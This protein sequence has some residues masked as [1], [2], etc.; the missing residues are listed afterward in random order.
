M[1]IYRLEA[2]IVRAR[3]HVYFR[4]HRKD[5]PQK[6]KI[7]VVGHPRSGTKSLHKLFTENGLRSLHF[8]GNWNTRKYDCFSDR[9][10]YQPLGLMRAYY[11]NSTFILNTRPAYKYIRS[12]MNHWFGKGKKKGTGWLNPGVKNIQNEILARNAFF[13]DFVRLFADGGNFLVVN[14]E[15]EGAFDFLCDRLGLER[16]PAKREAQKNWK[17]GHLQKI[18]DAFEGLG[19]ADSRMEPFVNADLVGDDDQALYQ[20]F[21]R[22]KQDRIYL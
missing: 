4:L 13:M 21:L 1:D 12:A 17:E 14:I 15:R 20:E 9:G 11:V 8:P 6:E 18:D 10:N 22:E 19:I 5:D 2:A 16:A 3:N 7:F